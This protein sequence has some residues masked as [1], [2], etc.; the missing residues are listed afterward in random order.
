MIQTVISAISNAFPDSHVF[1][2]KVSQGYDEDCFV[3][4]MDSGETEKMMKNRYL[5]TENV[6]VYF[7]SYEDKTDVLEQLL[8]CLASMEDGKYRP[9][10]LSYEIDDNELKI[11]LCF[12]FFTFLQDTQTGTMQ[13]CSVKI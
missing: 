11:S 3:V 2:E 8:V 5:Q 7:Y 12:N 6:S 13:N 10:K 4:M 9:C 1:S